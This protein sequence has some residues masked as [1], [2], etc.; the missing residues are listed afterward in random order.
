MNRRDFLFVPIS[1]IAAKASLAAG[2]PWSA[3]LLKGGFDGA[4]WWSGV[5][6]ELDHKWKTYWRMPGAGGI[7]PAFDMI[8]ENIKTSRVDYPIPESIAVKGVGKIIG[9]KD[10]VIFPIA[11]T[12]SEATR[13]VNVKLKAFFGVCDD[14]CI[15][16]S[17]D[18][19][20]VF[21]PTQSDAPDQALISQWR[22]KVPVLTAAGPVA[23]AEV[24]QD[25]GEIFVVFET[26]EPVTALFVEGDPMHYFQGSMLVGGQLRMKVSGAKTADEVRNTPLRLTMRTNTKVLEQIVTV[27]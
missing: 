24:Q 7:A 4:I 3:R 14:V 15:P 6:I 8:G 18:A 20:I 13:P 26:T 1:L 2:Q 21:D 11:I 25:A 27:V 10:T 22:A 17:L 12:P 23:K 16:A 19:D 9:Y 5:A